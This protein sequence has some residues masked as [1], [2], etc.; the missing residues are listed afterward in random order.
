MLRYVERACDFLDRRFVLE[1]PVERVS[2]LDRLVES[3]RPLSAL[4]GQVPE[5]PPLSMVFVPGPQPEWPLRMLRAAAALRAFHA[6]YGD[7]GEGHRQ[8]SR[9]AALL[10]RPAP[11]IPPPTDNPDG[12]AAYRR[13]FRDLQSE[14]GLTEEDMP[15]WFARGVDTWHPD[16]AQSFL[17][18]IPSLSQSRPSL[19]DVLAAMEWRETL[20]RCYPRPI[21]AT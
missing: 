12:W 15:L 19:D 8:S 17:E 21:S 18:A 4:R 20:R 10:E 5:F 2:E 9:A 16:R 1:Q 13:V 11:P 6:T 7:Q 14:C 3:W